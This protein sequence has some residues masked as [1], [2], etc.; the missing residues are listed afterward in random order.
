MQVHNRNYFDLFRTI[1]KQNPEREY[2]RK[3]SLNI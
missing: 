3:T 1:S 2:F